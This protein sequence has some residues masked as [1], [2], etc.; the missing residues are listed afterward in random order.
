MSVADWC[1]NCILKFTSNG[2]FV[3]HFGSYGSGPRQLNRLHNIT[4]DTTA[5][6]LV[7][8]SERGNDHI[9]V[10]T[11]DGVFV[12]SFEIKF[13]NTD[14]FKFPSILRFDKKGFVRLYFNSTAMS[15]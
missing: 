12:S 3:A 10:F 5:T 1:N 8:V 7:Y 2:K 11:S 6:G 4:I 15:K 13:S 9:S 14:Q